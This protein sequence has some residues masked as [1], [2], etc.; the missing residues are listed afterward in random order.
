MKDEEYFKERYKRLYNSSELNRKDSNNAF[1]S[2][3]RNLILVA[4]IIIAF[5]S[6][7]I[8]NR[9]TLSEMDYIIKLLLLHGWIFLFLSIVSGLVQ[10]Y[11][12]YKYFKSGF[13]AMVYFMDKIVNEEYDNK[14]KFINEYKNRNKEY[15]SNLCAFKTQVGFL[16]FGLILFLVFISTLIF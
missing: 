15:S 14:E 9:T 11:I 2:L 5:S 3:S 4:T 8:S 6:P 7:L 16:I 1:Y 12:D 10:Y 13:N